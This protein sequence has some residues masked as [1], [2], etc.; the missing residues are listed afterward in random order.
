M[1]Q[2]AGN[3]PIPLQ[4]PEPP[5]DPVKPLLLREVL[6]EEGGR[7]PATPLPAETDVCVVGGGFTG[8]WTAIHAKL[9]EP[10]AR[11]AVIEAGLCGG[12]ASGRN[13]G[14]LMSAGRRSPR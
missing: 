14:F 13:G 3:A 12:G 6:E 2:A 1:P 10:A 5:S 9:S 7:G 11:V 8:L 4:T